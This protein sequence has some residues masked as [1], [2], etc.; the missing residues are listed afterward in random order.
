[1]LP[2]DA[3]TG[4]FFLPIHAIRPG[5]FDW[6]PAPREGEI[7][8]FSWVHLQPSEGYATE[9]P[10]VL[11][12]IGLDAGPQLMANILNPGPEDAWI[13]RRVRLVFEDRADG[14]VVAQFAPIT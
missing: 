6:S 9:L 11:A 3:E 10:Y 14:A 13:G 2:R 12:T 4:E 5:P 8:S 7:V 1:M